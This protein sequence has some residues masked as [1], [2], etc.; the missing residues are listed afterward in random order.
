[1]IISLIR[2]KNRL[3]N[4]SKQSAAGKPRD[5]PPYVFLK[6]YCLFR[7]H[8]WWG[9]MTQE[10]PLCYENTIDNESGYHQEDRE[11]SQTLCVTPHLHAIKWSMKMVER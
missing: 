6:L 9:I 11:S 1:M 4:S 10:S 8:E 2:A 7:A 3:V 5:L